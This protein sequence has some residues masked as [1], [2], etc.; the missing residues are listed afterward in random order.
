MKPVAGGTRIKEAA[1]FIESGDFRKRVVEERL[2]LFAGG[3]PYEGDDFLLPCWS[4]TQTDLGILLHPKDH[5]DEDKNTELLT[6][7]RQA[8]AGNGEETAFFRAFAE[9]C[10]KGVARHLIRIEIRFC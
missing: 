1:R 3:E 6:Q 8:A 9:F 7:L 4:G 5:L 10:P 2:I